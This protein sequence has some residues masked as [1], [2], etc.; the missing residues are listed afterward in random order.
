MQSSIYLL[1]SQTGTN[2]SK[3]IKLFTRKPYNHASLS[4]DLSLSEMYSFCRTYKRFPI[5]A[6][7]NK[8]TVGKGVLG[9]FGYIPC[10]LYEIP[11]TYEQKKEFELLIEHF[12]SNR[13]NYSYNYLGLG[14]ILFNI[15]YKNKNKFLCSQ[16][17]AYILQQ[18]GIEL[19]KPVSLCTPEDLRHMPNCNLLYKGD[20]IQYYHELNKELKFKGAWFSTSDIALTI[21]FSFSEE[22][23][24]VAK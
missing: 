4:K 20:L 11:V 18:I 16:F 1:V 5:P 9:M 7:F 13:R 2:I 14:S 22:Y 23:I 6:T 21:V 15:R 17:A 19:K 8:E 3:A 24:Y 12:K 10:E